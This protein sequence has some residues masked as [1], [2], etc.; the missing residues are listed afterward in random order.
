MRIVVLC[1]IGPALCLAVATGVP[2]QTSLPSCQG[3]LHPGSVAELLFGRDIGHRVGVSR[4]AFSR[5]VTHEL[6]P[7]FPDGLTISTMTGQWR[8]PHSGTILREPGMRVE[9]VLPT[10]SDDEARLEA[11]VAAYKRLF[12][13][14]SVGII[15]RSACVAF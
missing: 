5:F 13:Q 12:H 8:D 2:A 4:A 9:I 10:K 14:Q 11:V 7:R 3:T 15:V 1:L 6:T